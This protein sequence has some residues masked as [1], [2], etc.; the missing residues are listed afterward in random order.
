MNFFKKCRR[1]LHNF[2]Y[3]TIRAGEKQR[4][5]HIF[6]FVLAKKGKAAAAGAVILADCLQNGNNFFCLPVIIKM[7]V[8]NVPLCRTYKSVF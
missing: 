2:H 4:F 8:Q 5:L 6:S 3:Y 1:V 7:Y